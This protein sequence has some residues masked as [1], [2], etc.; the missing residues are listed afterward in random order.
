MTALVIEAGDCYTDSNNSDAVGI[1]VLWPDYSIGDLLIVN[2]HMWN[3]NPYG[4]NRTIS[5][6]PNG[7]D[8]E[9]FTVVVNTSGAT[10][11]DTVRIAIGYYIATDDY[12]NPGTQ[13]MQFI[14]SANTR[15]ATVTVV[16]PAGEFNADD[17]ISSAFDDKD[18]TGTTP[19][20]DAFSANSDDTDGKMLVFVGADQD[21]VTGTP[22]GYTELAETDG[23]RA[24][25]NLGGR[26][27]AVTSSESISASAGW[28]IATDD[29]SVYAYIVKTFVAS[30]T[31]N[32]E[33]LQDLTS[34]V[35][36]DG[37][38]IQ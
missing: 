6:W 13:D 22:T 28:T 5:S 16:V 15:F 24:A 4:A 1:G 31:I 10:G 30:G 23:G 34:C 32:N 26:D 7:W 11:N 17:P 18:G 29:W 2:I 20:F 37:S 21:P 9:T 36:E 19:N 38:P 3:G 14:A 33:T 35:V 12:T 27:A 8:G 25:V